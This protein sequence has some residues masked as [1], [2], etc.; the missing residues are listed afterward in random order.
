[1]NLN[2]TQYDIFISYR[3][4]DGFATA[5]LI[6]DRLER[7]GYQVAFDMETLQRSDFDVQ[8]YK[9]IENCRDFITV[10]SPDALKLRQDPKNDW[11]RLE[12]AHALKCKKNIIPVFSGNIV[13]PRKDDLPEDISG[14]ITKNGVTVSEEYFAASYKKLC[15]LLTSRKRIK[16]AILF[17]A[18]FITALSLITVAS[19]LYAITRNI[20]SKT[21]PTANNIPLESTSNSDNQNIVSEQEVTVETEI[22][23]QTEEQ[24][25]EDAKSQGL[26]LS[27]DGKTLKNC[28]N[29]NIKKCIIPDG[30][31]T[32]ESYAFYKCTNLKNIIIPNSVTRIEH[33]AFADCSSLDILIIPC[34]V[35]DIDDGAFAGVPA[36]K[37]NSGNNFFGITDGG[38]LIDRRNKRFLYLPPR[39][40]GDYTIPEGIKS[41]GAFAFSGCNRLTTVTIPDSVV[42]IENNAFSACTS[43]SR[44]V[45]GNGV[46]RIGERVFDHCK[47]LT[48]VIIGNSVESIGSGAFRG[49][50]NL[51]RITIPH[52]VNQL[53]SSVFSDCKSLTEIVI[54]NS[55]TDIGFEAFKNCISLRKVVLGNSIKAIE[56]SLFEDCISLVDLSIGNNVTSIGERAFYGCN[57]ITTLKIPSNVTSIEDG[58]FAKVQSVKV[59]PGNPYFKITDDGAL[60]DRQNKRIIYLPTAFS[61]T[62]TI[63]DGMEIIA[64]Y[65]FAGCINL[66]G[67]VTGNQVTTIKRDAF[68]GCNLKS[69]LIGNKVS[70]IY[71]YPRIGQFARWSPGNPYFKITNE[72]AVIDIQAKSI[73]YLPRDYQGTYAIPDGIVEIG[74][75]AFASC[76]KLSGVVIPNSVGIIANSAFYGCS[77]ITNVTFPDSVKYIGLRAFALTGIKKVILPKDCHYNTFS[78]LSPFPSFPSNCKITGGIDITAEH[79]K[80]EAPKFGLSG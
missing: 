15:R 28:R 79:I 27:E 60:I 47:S 70:T 26:I 75:G 52:S 53:G 80:K 35:M 17:T 67:I 34:S 66:T 16:P 74:N 50:Y 63:P 9:H 2:T 22:K 77:K 41:I 11:F 37:V 19:C 42:S 6:Y 4:S 10:L 38:A 61:G 78:L 24:S 7:D 59:S 46:T 45:I 44:G 20:S 73:I 14:I 68:H 13:L 29:K 40:K 64:D 36:V 1:M 71:N 58:A 12:T 55:V 3:R 32:I 51:T 43:L 5:R 33:G 72:G 23:Q 56:K 48:N 30:V 31:T 69:I 65:T 76:N 39:H 49:C 8:L 25:V 54:G 62:Y 18:F 21:S 57:N